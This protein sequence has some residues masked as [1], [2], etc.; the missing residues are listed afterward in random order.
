MEVLELD[1]NKL[2]GKIPPSL[3]LIGDSLT[4][5]LTL[6]HNKLSDRIPDCFGT[7][8]PNLATMQLQDNSL[9]GGLPQTWSPTNAL[10]SLMVSNNPDLGGKLPDS[11]FKMSDLRAVIAEGSGLKGSLPLELCTHV[12][13]WRRIHPSDQQSTSTRLD[14]V[15]PTLSRL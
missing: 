12:Q 14:F 11:L 15:F 6:N 10:N 13:S 3:C 2:D 4:D 5:F 1:Q 9:T 8:F 7:S